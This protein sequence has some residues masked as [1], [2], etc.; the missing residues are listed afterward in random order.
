MALALMRAGSPNRFKSASRFSRLS[1]RPEN[2]SS[3]KSVLVMGAAGA[4]CGLK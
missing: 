4:E 3:N 1:G 2:P